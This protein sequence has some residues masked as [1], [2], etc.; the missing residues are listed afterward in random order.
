MMQGI[1]PGSQ[2]KV[3]GFTF[4][5][6]EFQDSLFC[7]DNKELMEIY[8]ST[9]SESSQSLEF[10]ITKCQPQPQWE[11]NCK[12]E[13]ELDSLLNGAQ[14]LLFFNQITFD[15]TEFGE[16]SVKESFDFKQ[17]QLSSTIT[18]KHTLQA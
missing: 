3:D 6:E 7:I 4:G 17:F 14:F 1:L 13:E 9:N 2:T 5:L 18:L 16:A 8:G 11:I 10:R 15:T 12:P